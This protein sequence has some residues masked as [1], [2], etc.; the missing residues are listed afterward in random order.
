MATPFAPPAN[1]TESVDENGNLVQSWPFPDDATTMSYKVAGSD[2]V[3]TIAIPQR[4]VGTYPL[5]KAGAV[6]ESISLNGKMVRDIGPA[7]AVKGLNAAALW[8]GL[9]NDVALA[10]DAQYTQEG[11]T[12]SLKAEYD[13]I[14]GNSSYGKVAP[15][16]HHRGYRFYRGMVEANG[17]YWLVKEYVEG[18]SP[19]VKVPINNVQAAYDVFPF[20]YGSGTGSDYICTDGTRVY[21]TRWDRLGD[22]HPNRTW[23]AAYDTTTNQSYSFTSGSTYR[24]NHSNTDESAAFLL[25]TDDPTNFITGLAVQRTGNF[26]VAS[27][28]AKNQYVVANKLTGVVLK[29]V[30]FTSP[31]ELLFDQ[32]DHLWI[33]QGDVLT[34]VS[35]AA[36]GTPSGALATVSVTDV[37]ALTMLL[38]LLVFEEA[39]SK[40]QVRAVDSNG[41]TQWVHGTVGGQQ[42]FSLVI[43]G[44]Y[45]FSDVSGS[46]HEG[47]LLGR[48]D[49][50]LWVGDCGN[51]RIEYLSATRTKLDEIAYQGNSYSG[52]VDLND[53]TRVFN[54]WKEFK[55]DYTKP[56]APAK[57]HRN[58][59][60]K[61]P[62][63]LFGLHNRRQN[64]ELGTIL[65][66]VVTFPSGRTYGTARYYADAST[67][68]LYELT[69]AG[70]VLVK[71]ISERKTL[72][73]DGS[74]YFAQ[75]ALSPLPGTIRY[76]K[77]SLTSDP[78]TGNPTWGFSTQID[79]YT[80][81]TANDPADFSGFPPTDTYIKTEDGTRP[82]F[83]SGLVQRSQDGQEYGT[84]GPRL[85]GVPAGQ[86]TAAWKAA[87]GTGK[88]YKGPYPRNG[89]YP[90]GNRAIDQNGN[91]NGHNNGVVRTLGPLII[92][93]NPGE[94]ADDAQY[95]FFNV[96][97]QRGQFLFTFGVSQR[98]ANEAGQRIGYPGMA[99][100]VLM[101]GVAIDP[102]NPDVGY[103]Y[104]SSEGGP[105]GT[106]RWKITGLLSIYPRK[107]RTFSIQNG[108]GFNKPKREGVD[109]LAEPSRWTS[110]IPESSNFYVELGTLNPDKFAGKS[111]LI[112]SRTNA[113][114]I[115][116]IGPINS[117]TWSVEAIVTFDRNSGNDGNI[118]DSNSG[119]QYYQVCDVNGKVLARFYTKSN[120]SPPPA[121]SEIWANNTLLLQQSYDNPVP[122]ITDRNQRLIIKAVDGQ[123]SVS[124]AGYSANV[125]PLESGALVNQPATLRITSW[126]KGQVRDRIIG[127]LDVL[128]KGG[129]QPP[130]TPGGVTYTAFDGSEQNLDNYEIIL[131]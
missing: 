79:S 55:P 63:L 61:A 34:R 89:A 129:G 105:S 4:P 12:H 104:H 110:S 94:G 10:A 128:V 92:Y 25:T 116:D 26:Q 49:G 43:D 102:T 41:T 33:N 46:V 125:S 27:Y 76:F 122:R 93:N 131:I 18:P 5:P 74:L 52:G 28:A 11:I 64:I 70:L 83:Q 78:L 40:Q 119:G 113:E 24:P 2:E 90:N 100:N 85:V 32:N 66:N 91:Q 112:F 108:L 56:G 84:T 77:E 57:L 73:A 53:P 80:G 96:H 9:T 23:V 68:G 3:K 124:Y 121:K 60:A 1:V 59:G 14:L 22:Q 48:S 39:G 67:K 127:L 54:T 106:M 45:Y 99:G 42:A 19:L 97:Y 35:L 86:T 21:Y 107:A 65:A 75:S 29:T 115:G 117:S 20:Y 13:G 103:I 69:D 95:N 51:N 7:A 88:F 17:Y 58:W 38:G 87:Y 123:L 31:K 16:L 126:E 130:V 47:F 72:G 30:S 118:Q 50:T 101:F 6:A 36:D 82:V 15:E 109:M 71:T 111:R 37:V 114:H 62:A 120:F 44:R 81:I 98:E 8:D